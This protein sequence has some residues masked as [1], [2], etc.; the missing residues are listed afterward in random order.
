MCFVNNRGTYLD[1]STDQGTIFL[2]RATCRSAWQDDKVDFI[3]VQLDSGADESAAPQRFEPALCPDLLVSRFSEFREDALGAIDEGYNSVLGVAFLAML[4]GILAK[5]TTQISQVIHRSHELATMRAVGAGRRQVAAL[6]T[7]ETTFLGSV[8]I[9]IGLIA[10]FSI[11]R[12]ILSIA[13]EALGTHLDYSVPPLI[14]V[15]AVGL[16]LVACFAGAWFPVRYLTRIDL[17]QVLTR[18]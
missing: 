4:M 15:L 10:G 13:K 12:A 18:E 7:L 9:I 5:A 6:I 3:K 14:I 8:G 17:R 11:L 16:G 1:Y 2:D